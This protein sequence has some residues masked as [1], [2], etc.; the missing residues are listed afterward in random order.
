ML[1]PT[2]MVSVMLNLQWK[3]VMRLL[4]TL[5]IIQIATTIALQFTRVQP[6]SLMP[7]LMDTEAEKHK[8][9]VM[10]QRFHQDTFFRTQALIAT[11]TIPLS[12]RVLPKSDIT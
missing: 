12:I 7:I 4:A 2:M 9:Y 1:I 11:I 5:Q 10:E 6:C 8:R 3:L